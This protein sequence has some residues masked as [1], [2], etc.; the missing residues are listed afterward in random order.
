MRLN[1]VL[2]ELASYPFTRL[3]AA[4]QELVARGV[5]VIDFG[6]GEPR[7]E[8]PSFI[9]D[10]LA[11]AIPAQSAYPLAAGLP[12]YRAAAAGWVQRRFGVTLDPEAELVPTLGSKEAIFHLVHVAGPGAVVVT[13]PG[14]PVAERAALFDR[15]EVVGVPLTAER[16]FLPDLDAVPWADAAIVWLNYPNNPTAATAP[17]ELYEEAAARAREHGV[18]LAS[19]EAYSELFFAG[20]PS[21]SALQV[22]DRTGLLVL[23]TLSKRSSMPGFRIGFAAGDPA[24]VAALKRYRPNVGVAPQDFVQRAGIA[25]WSDEEHVGAVR[26]AYRAK[27]DVVLPV[28]EAAGLR[29]AGGNA[30]FFLWLEAPDG[31]AEALLERGIVVAPGEFFGPAGRGYVRVALVPT[32]AECE[33]AVQRITGWRAASR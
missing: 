22:A 23:H 33:Q 29:N 26:E 21:A 24:L 30:T 25:A 1:P 16:G 13:E 27:R 4:K 12:E 11:A 3:V 17:L 15:R 6:M 10:A 7:E 9:R 2:E 31:T 5:E 32:L 14:Y 8:T 20:E 28:L 18:V 19:D